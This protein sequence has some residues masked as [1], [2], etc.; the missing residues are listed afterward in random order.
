MPTSIVCRNVDTNKNHGVI[1]TAHLIY[2]DKIE[3]LRR[4]LGWPLDAVRNTT[5]IRKCF[6]HLILSGWVLASFAAAGGCV[7]LSIP[8]QCQ[9]CGGVHLKWL[10]GLYESNKWKLWLGVTHNAVVQYY[11][12]WFWYR[13]IPDNQQVE[14]N[15]TLCVSCMFCICARRLAPLLIFIF[16]G[17]FCAVSKRGAPFIDCP[18]FKSIQKNLLCWDDR[19]SLRH[20]HSH[21]AANE[22]LVHSL[23][24]NRTETGIRS[25]HNRKCS[26]D[27]MKRTDSLVQMLL[28]EE[29]K[30]F[31]PQGVC[32]SFA[33][34]LSSWMNGPVCLLDS[35]EKEKENLCS[36]SK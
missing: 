25:G 10:S 3:R 36:I 8:E 14:R 22:T 4:R 31:I 12:T 5:S 18:L 26:I 21:T 11:N 29:V 30:A 35:Q 15:L 24:C 16:V 7:L 6:I 27:Y 9:Q 34:M 17:C 28:Y 13:I 33:V 20:K 1:T 2:K 32:W 19:T 23:P